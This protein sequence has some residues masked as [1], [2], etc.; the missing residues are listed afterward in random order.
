[1]ILPPRPQD[2]RRLDRPDPPIELR[3]MLAPLPPRDAPDLDRFAVPPWDRQSSESLAIDDD[4]PADHLARAIDEAVDRLDLTDLFASYAGFGS[5]PHR[6]DL[7]LKIVL[8]EIE[9]GHHSPSQWAEDAHDRRC[10]LWLGCGIKPSRSR[11]Y[12][13]RDRVGARLGDWNRQVLQGLR[14]A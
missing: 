7:M 6:P 12:A 11:C 3:A 5:K 1:M 13:F 10:L 14:R 2:D 4:L 9:T 8:Y